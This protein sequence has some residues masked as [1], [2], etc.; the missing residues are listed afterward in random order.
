MCVS[1][2]VGFGQLRSF[3]QILMPVFNNMIIHLLA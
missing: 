2:P 3:G 1:M